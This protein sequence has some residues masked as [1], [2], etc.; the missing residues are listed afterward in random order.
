MVPVSMDPGS[1]RVPDF[2][3]ASEIDTIIDL[4]FRYCM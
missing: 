2:G 3:G 1:E 4:Y